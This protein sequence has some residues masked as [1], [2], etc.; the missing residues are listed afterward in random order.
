MDGVG[1]APHREPDRG[2][3]QNS[4]PDKDGNHNQDDLQCAT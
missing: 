4:Q 2:R 3:T 1:N